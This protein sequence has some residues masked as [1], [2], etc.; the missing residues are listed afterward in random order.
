MDTTPRSRLTAF[1]AVGVFLI[2]ASVAVRVWVQSG[3]EAEPDYFG[4]PSEPNRLVEAEGV[5]LDLTPVLKSEIAHSVLN[6]RLPDALARGRFAGTVDVADLTD[7]APKRISQ[8]ELPALTMFEQPVEKAESQV[9]R[10]DLQLW[11][12]LFASVDYFERAGF[13]I[14]RGEFDEDNPERIHTE[15][16]F[17]G[18]ARDAQNRMLLIE[19]KQT[20]TWLPATEADEHSEDTEWQIVGWHQK[21]MKLT[22]ADAPMFAESL[23]AIIPDPALRARLRH[24]RHE[25]Y[26]LEQYAALLAEQE[27]TPPHPHFT[28][29]SQD[30][31]PA[32]SVVD[33]DGD[34]L[35]DLYVMA[36]WG[37]NILLHNRGGWFED[38]AADVG[39]DVDSFCSSA[40]FADFDN[41]GDPDLML[42]RTLEPSMYFENVDGR[43]IDRSDTLPTG[44]LPMLVSSVS[45]AD[46]NRDGLLDVYFATYAADLLEN[47]TKS[48]AK[49]DNRSLARFL[50]E[51]DARLLSDKLN[52]RQYDRYLSN[53]GPPNLLLA[54]A[55]GGSFEVAAHNQ[56]A[57]GWRHTYQGSWS[58]F[59]N[60]GDPDLYLAN[61]F[62]VNILL[63]NDGEQGFV[64]VA[65]E[66]GTTDIGFGMGASWGDFDGDGRQDLY[67]SNMFSKAGQRITGQLENID[68]RFGRMARGNSLF[69]AQDQGFKK[70]SGLGP[71]EL[72]VEKAGWSWSGQF[73]DVDN[74]GW[75]DVHALSGYYT[76]PKEIAVQV[77][78]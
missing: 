21:S 12:P 68:T 66:A 13:S 5:I 59:D 70:V 33:Y 64:D 72:H 8:I 28:F 57:Q 47:E 7:T 17:E 27:W 14:V 19:A 73:V 65:E 10:D 4:T 63:R 60:D 1:A 42:G 50:S 30:R 56:S 22:E 76:A 48:A 58:D 52:S 61:D 45:V 36:R 15:V 53:A 26:I 62:A 44:A 9:P 41:D 55:G 37:K 39:L 20:I 46:F 18:V 51:K 38:A 71:G 78:L 29:V 43:Y 32:V 54:N 67:V 24:S 75:L 49:S 23:D 2:A 74:D 40:A 3:S 31:H 11:Q 34:G 25:D 16:S 6:L 35:D 77:D 69:C